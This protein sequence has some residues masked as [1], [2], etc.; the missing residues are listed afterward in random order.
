MADR[1][2][3]RAPLRVCRLVG[4]LQEPVGHP[5]GHS[6][7]YAPPAALPQVCCMRSVPALLMQALQ[8]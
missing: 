2:C 6:C 7:V 3:R 1:V 5:R 4:L 8:C